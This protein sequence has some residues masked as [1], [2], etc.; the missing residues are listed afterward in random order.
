M[1]NHI[2]IFNGQKIPIRNQQIPI[3]ENITVENKNI[4]FQCKNG[5]CGS[6]R[7]KL[8]SGEICY[9]KPKIGITKPDEI[10][11]CIAAANSDLVLHQE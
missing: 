6:C 10:L 1:T 2:I 7:C 9:Q 3:L 11:I 5:V 4:R 8:I